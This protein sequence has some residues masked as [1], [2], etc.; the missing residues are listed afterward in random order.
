MFGLF[1]YA[2]Y[3]IN[4]RSFH[5]VLSMTMD[6]LSWSSGLGCFIQNHKN[7]SLNLG[8]PPGFETQP[9]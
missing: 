1:V 3:V 9:C 6:S 8:T 2:C 4:T 7:P 5:C